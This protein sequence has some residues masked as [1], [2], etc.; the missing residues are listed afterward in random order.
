[1]RRLF[2][3]GYIGNTTTMSKGGRDKH[4]KSY[5]CWSHM[6]E[7]CY[8]EKYHKMRPSYVDCEVCEEWLC[9]ETFEKWYDNNYYEL[10]SGERVELDKDILVRGNKIYSPQTCVFLPQTINFAIALKKNKEYLVSL[11]EAYKEYI[12]TE[13][14]NALINWEV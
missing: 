13:V 5:R 4:K 8:S 1:M 3:I 6:L 11:A 2:D 9:Y 10:P 7:R 12:S 14:Y